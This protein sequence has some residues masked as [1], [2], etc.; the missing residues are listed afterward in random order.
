V[1]DPGTTGKELVLACFYVLMFFLLLCVGCGKADDA[2]VMPTT[3]FRHQALKAK[4]VRAH[5]WGVSHVA[6]QSVLIGTSVVYCESVKERPKVIKV[7]RRRTPK[8]IVLTM[9]MRF[10]RFPENCFGGRLGIVHWVKIGPGIDRFDLFDGSTSPPARR[11]E[12]PKG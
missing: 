9:Y 4:G 3:G 11:R 1:V 12:A 7:S 6:N 5:R 8:G 10:P 2:S